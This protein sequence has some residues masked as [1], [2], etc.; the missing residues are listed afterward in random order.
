VPQGACSIVAAS[1]AEK[2][3]PARFAPILEPSG[4]LI[5]QGAGEAK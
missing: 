2:A 3:D 4:N 5:G 1:V